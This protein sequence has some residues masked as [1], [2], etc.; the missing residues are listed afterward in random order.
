MKKY[1]L[2]LFCLFGGLSILSAQSP[3]IKDVDGNNITNST[4]NFTFVQTHTVTKVVFLL[5]NPGGNE[6]VVSMRKVEVDILDGT[7][8]DFCFAGR[9]YQPS[10]FLAPDKMPLAPGSTTDHNDCY[11]QFYPGGVIGSSTIK[12]EFFSDDKSFE[13]VYVEVNF[14]ATAPTNIPS[15]PFADVVFSD[16]YPNPARGH[17]TIDYQLS[18]DVKNARIILRSLTGQVVQTFPLNTNANSIRIDTSS[19]NSGMYFYSIELNNQ[20]FLSKRLIVGR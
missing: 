10:V 18:P 9:C 8:N 7:D 4:L 3:I 5:N 15:P 13:T 6:I 2:L 20:V 1:L 14:T 19:L 12:Y 11:A 16:P 17:T